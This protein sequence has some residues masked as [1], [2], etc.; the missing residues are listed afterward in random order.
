M[1][2]SISVIVNVYAHRKYV[3]A[4]IESAIHQDG[5][6]RL[7]VILLNAIEGY[8]P[9]TELYQ[10][11]ERGGVSLRSMPVP[12]GPVGVGLAK[13]FRESTGEVI[14]LLDEDDLWQ[15]NKLLSVERAFENR[16]V[17]YYHHNQTFVDDRNRGLSRANLHRL[18]RHPSSLLAEGRSW[19]IDSTDPVS[20][21]RIRHLEP[22]FNNSSIAVRRRVIGD[23][24]GIVEQ[25]SRGEDTIL[26]YCALGS[27]SLLN[28]STSRLTRYRI[29]AG[30]VTAVSPSDTGQSSRLAGYISDTEKRLQQLKLLQPLLAINSNPAIKE[31]L[32]SEIAFYSVLR[33]AGLGDA[34][35]GQVREW[36][37]Q[38]FGGAFAR[39]RFKELLTIYLGLSSV[40]SRS[41][42]RR[43]LA[44]W[45]SH[46]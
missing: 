37:G 6:R 24:L 31:L 33:S 14:C 17:V 35:I 18:I 26:F 22:D 11:A 45:R 38:L 8:A 40:V 28:L 27:R 5:D 7:E 21:S 30:G 29:H 41:S 3:D 46:R 1:P 25:A 43:V 19:L 10:A 36:T 42:S 44:F 4:A 12:K 9:S 13:G 23:N 16:D 15:P 2:V 34:Q 39:P 20:L 32:D